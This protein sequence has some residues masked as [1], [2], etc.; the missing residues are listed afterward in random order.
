MTS[1]F[2]P[3]ILTFICTGHPLELTKRLRGRAP[4]DIRVV[5]VTCSHR[6]EPEIMLEPFLANF[7]GVLILECPPDYCRS[8]TET[9]SG[10]ERFYEI[11]AVLAAAHI[12]TDRLCLDR[13]PAIKD[14]GLYDIAGKFTEK[15]ISLGPLH[16]NKV[17]REKLRTLQNNLETKRIRG[18]V[19][20]G[21]SQV[22]PR[23]TGK[24]RLCP[25]SA[26][27]RQDEYIKNWLSVLIEENPVTL[28]HLG[29]V[30]D[31]EVEYISNYLLAMEKE[32]RIKIPSVLKEEISNLMN[33]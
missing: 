19:A 32:Q 29:E 30:M 9:D 23:K 27:A 11:T 16:L 28:T 25:S 4:V 7:D 24:K 12:Q 21:L 2:E 22:N 1:G 8:R 15:I 18:L 10:A 31:I 5:K 13:I 3:R 20:A 6:I 17:A 14:S 33:S 26:T